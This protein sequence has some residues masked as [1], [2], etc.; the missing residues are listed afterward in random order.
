MMDTE[1]LMA[2]L[3]D[4][5]RA[6]GAG[7]IL[8]ALSLV[9]AFLT[10]NT[11]DTGDSLQHYLSSRY[12]LAH[13]QLFFDT[14]AKPLFVLL[15]VGPAQA[16]F[17]GMLVFQCVVAA[18]SAHLAFRVAQQLRLP[19]PWLAVPFVYAAPD[20]FLMQFSGLTE[21]LFGLVLVA[22]VALAVRG[23]AGWSGAVLS[24]LPFVRAEGF[25]LLA[26]WAVYLVASRQVRWLP[27]LGLGFAVYS[28]VGWAVLGEL[29]WVFGRNAYRY[30]LASYG[31]GGWADFVT[32]LP[33]LLGWV[34]VVLFWV[35]LGRGL[36]AWVRPT[37]RRSP[38]H[39]PAEL[40]LLYGSIVAYIGAHSTFWALG[41]FQSLGMTRV[42]AALTPLAA[43]VALSGLDVISRLGQTARGRRRLQLGLA[44]LVVLFP[45]TGL[46]HALRWQRDFRPAGRA[47]VEPARG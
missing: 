18:G 45:V 2:D 15:T 30:K 13:P 8:L 41:I 37:L 34:L 35:G 17:I 39:W 23:R 7:I 44:V 33:G 21:P 25:I 47:G 11:Y 10:Q 26:V 38:A 9:V 42:L 16:G 46:N 4:S 24:W 29:G 14:W 36:A 3:A 27:L 22:G 19:L 28:L 5:R 20:Y 43:V 32:Q 6:Y 31:H 1:P 12:A 40:L